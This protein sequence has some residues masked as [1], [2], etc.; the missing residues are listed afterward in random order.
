MSKRDRK[1]SHLAPVPPAGA[2]P[3]SRVTPE[4]FE[5]PTGGNAGT[6]GLLQE[7]ARHAFPR[8]LLGF[9]FQLDRIGPRCFVTVQVGDGFTP[10]QADAGRAAIARAL[11][12]LGILKPAATAKAS[13]EA[14]PA[15]GEDGAESPPSQT[16]SSP[17]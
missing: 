3:R 7:L 16:P 15:A 12:A 6:L 17:S 9:E 5:L 2:A 1:A 10:D 14:T 4:R 11:A 13:P 8:A